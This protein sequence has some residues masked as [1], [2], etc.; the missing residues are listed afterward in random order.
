LAKRLKNIAELKLND[1]LLRFNAGDFEITVFRDARA[2]IRGTDD[3]TTARA[4][5]AKFIGS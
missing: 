3:A 4:L 5:Y 1:Y 2:I